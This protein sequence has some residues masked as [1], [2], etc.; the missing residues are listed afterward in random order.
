MNIPG[1]Q[2]KPTKTDSLEVLQLL[3]MTMKIGLFPEGLIDLMA[4][5]PVRSFPLKKKKKKGSI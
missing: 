1:P 5:L 4:S 3:W 2:A